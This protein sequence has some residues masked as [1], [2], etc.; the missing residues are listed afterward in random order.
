MQKD[1]II[2]TDLD[3]D[4]C[5]SYL[6]YTWFNQTKPTA[7][8]LKVSNISTKQWSS[9]VLELN[10]IKKAWL[11]HG[12]NIKLETPGLKRILSMG[13]SNKSLD[14]YEENIRED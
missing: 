11:R 10:L 6:I 7:I 8:T 4:G 1:K 13:T 2:F 14:P 3:F 12:P 5:C 9:L